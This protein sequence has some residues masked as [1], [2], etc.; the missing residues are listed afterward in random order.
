MKFT[1]NRIFQ[2]NGRRKFMEYGINIGFL[3]KNISM[4]KA[5]EL[6]SRVGFTVL[7][8]TPPVH[9]DNWKETMNSH[10]KIFDFY[11][12]SVH[13]THAPFNR[14][15]SYGDV[16]NHKKC[17]D[18]CAEASEAMGAKYIVVHGDEFDKEN[19][20][21]SPKAALEY[22]HNMFLP[23]VERAE[24]HG[25]YKIAFETVFEDSPS[26]RRFTSNIDELEALIK[27]FDSDSAVCC[28]DFGHAHV[29]F[30]KNH[31]SNVKRMGGL[32][33]CTHLHDN[34][35]ND[36]HQIPMTGDIDWKSVMSSFHEIGYNGN[37]SVEYAHGNIPESLTEQ[38]LSLSIGATRQL[39]SL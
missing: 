10:K 2:D 23:Y 38:F 17:L 28:W 20:T 24:K 32:I 13:Q 26:F 25:D 19:M 18:R 30:K 27:S 4:E 5:A 11:G 31:T 39:W 22:N 12:L 16:K 6:V 35:G 37:L 8:Y 34:A 7:D 21:F 33:Q 29:S 3:T 36:S 1:T 9:E 15:G 14:Y